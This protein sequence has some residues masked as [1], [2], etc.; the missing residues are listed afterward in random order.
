MESF[1]GPSPSPNPEN[2][3]SMSELR[4]FH[5]QSPSTAIT[6]YFTY[7]GKIYASDF[8][9]IIFEEAGVRKIRLVSVPN[10]LFDITEDLNNVRDRFG[11]GMPDTE[12]INLLTRMQIFRLTPR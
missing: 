1:P 6:R 4:F 8:Q 5:D 7:Q 9:F 3:T 11:N 12:S 2:I 10:G